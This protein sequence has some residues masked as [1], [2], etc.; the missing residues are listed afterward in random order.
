M[1]SC[2]KRWGHHFFEGNLSGL[3]SIGNKRHVLEA[4]ANMSKYLGCY[5]AFRKL[6]EEAGLK[7]YSKSSERVFFEIMD[8]EES[9]GDTERWMDGL[10]GRVDQNI[11][12]A[13][14]FMGYN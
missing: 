3:E 8:G 2:A 10:K 7:W 6:K 5:S 1:V 4:I 11:W 13:M 14:V 9:A 12:T